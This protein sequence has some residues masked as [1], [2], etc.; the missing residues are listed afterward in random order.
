MKLIAIF[1]VFCASTAAAGPQ[2]D[3]LL[4]RFWLPEKDGQLEIYRQGDSYSGRVVAYDVA[5][6][7]DEKNPEPELRSRPIVGLDL[8]SGFRFD[9]KSDRWE[10]GTI[11]DAKSGKTYQCRLWFDEDD[12]GVL[13]AR[14]YIGISILGRT[15]QFIRVVE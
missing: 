9:E 3:A 11:Y 1:L 5:G 14:G 13:W 15:E 2:S 12:F 10:G 4:G 6:Q 8:L 7:L